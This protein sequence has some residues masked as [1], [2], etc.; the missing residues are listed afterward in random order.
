MLL[1]VLGGLASLPKS[2]LEILCEKLSTNFCC[3]NHGWLRWI[4]FPANDERQHRDRFGLGIDVFID[5]E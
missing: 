5:F 4:R 1:H 3:R 2:K